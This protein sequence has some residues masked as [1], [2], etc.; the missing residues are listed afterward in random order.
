MN[1]PVDYDDE[2]ERKAN[3]PVLLDTNQDDEIDVPPRNQNTH[4]ADPNPVRR[5]M[6]DNGIEEVRWDLAQVPRKKGLLITTR[7]TSKQK[8]F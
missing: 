3:Q 8:D 7:E 2:V 5:S 6:L 4:Q 1:I